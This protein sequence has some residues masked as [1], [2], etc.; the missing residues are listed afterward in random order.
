MFAGNNTCNNFFGQYELLEGDRIKFGQAGSTLMACPDGEIEKAFME[1]L[2]I[3]DNYNVVD[4]VLILN[5]AKMAPLARFEQ[6]R[7]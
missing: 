3:A 5:K 1:V 2:R 4:G 7:D 6:E